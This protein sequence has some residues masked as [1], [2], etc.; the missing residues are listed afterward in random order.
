MKT[1]A[2]RN[3]VRFKGEIPLEIK[4]GMGITRDFSAC[5]LY[6]F[7]D[8]QVSLGESLELVMLLEHQ[9]QGQKVRLRCQ[10]DVV[11][12]EHEADR[13]G[14]AVAITKHLVDAAGDAAA[15]LTV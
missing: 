5:G 7:T 1:F 14:I 8:Q 15:S 4:Q 10:A 3:S 13:F 2:E 12:V 11:R 9:N 6:F